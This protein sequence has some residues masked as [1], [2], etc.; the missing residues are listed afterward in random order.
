M[1]KQK[2]ASK[3]N[4]SFSVFL[5][6][7]LYKLQ[8]AEIIII[9]SGMGSLSA[10]AYL[11]SEGKKVTIIEQNLLPGGCTSSYFRKG[12]IFESGATTLVGLDDGMPLN[13]LLTKTGI[14]I[15]AVPLELPMQVVLKDGRIIN[16]H[17]DLELW[18]A[19][20]EK[21]F[22]KQGQ[23]EFWIECFNISKFVWDVSGKQMFFPP[24][25]Y[26]DLWEMIKNFQFNQ[27]GFATK[28]FTTVEDVLKKYG[29]NENKIFVDFVNE[30]L[31][32]TAQ[33]H[34]SEVNMLFGATALC[35]TNFGNY[36]IPG[37][38]I[39]LVKPIIKYIEE[40]GGVF[41]NRTSITSISEK[42]QNFILQT[43]KGAF[44]AKQI[45]SGI[46]V[47]NVIDLFD[48]KKFFKKVKN[49]IMESDRL[50]GAFTMGFG[51]KGEIPKGAIH[52][53]IHLENPI[54]I[55]GAKSIFISYSHPD[56]LSRAPE[57]HYVAS[58]STHVKNPAM[59]DLDK[60][61]IAKTLSDILVEKGCFRKEEII[62]SHAST[63]EN[64]QDWT[65]RKYGFVG[66][67]PQYK[68]IKP[69]KMLSSRIFEGIY[70]CGDSVYP[71]QGIPGVTLSGMIAAKKLLKDNN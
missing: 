15:H 47:N 69:W 53:Q 5:I 52:K 26:T 39:N 12:Y 27:L 18:I 34:A 50:N 70:L 65:L 66:G 49:K 3:H 37:G 58:V 44:Q 59:Y 22:G 33:N 20:A 63:P 46:P 4:Q 9:G 42:K 7:Y 41:I 48:D 32:I 60:E 71:G 28:A 25:K 13:L 67:Y 56:D 68:S 24:D 55:P 29:L 1:R 31:M 14:Q 11:A 2:A 45:I 6:Q 64:W 23:R 17:K 57:G 51:I 36:Y 8:E 62:Y 19:E 16:R 30:Q 35:Y 10:G 38:L 54:E 40:K 43:S 61:I 21:F